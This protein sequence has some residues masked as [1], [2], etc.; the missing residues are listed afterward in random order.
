MAVQLRAQLGGQG[1]GLVPVGVRH[2]AGLVPVLLGEGDEHAAFEVEARPR[3]QCVDDGTRQQQRCAPARL[4]GVSWAS[5]T[6]W[7]ASTTNTAPAP[8][9]SSQRCPVTTAAVSS[10]M[11]TPSSDGEVA[12]TDISRP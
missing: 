2:R 3:R 9:T 10:S 11:P 8:T 1:T 7:W 4:V 12:T 6:A 5:E